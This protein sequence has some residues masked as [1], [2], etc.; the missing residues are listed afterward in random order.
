MKRVVENATHV[1]S[2]SARLFDL[3]YNDWL[4]PVVIF[5]REAFLLFWGF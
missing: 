5:L 2:A 3:K 1:D 4:N